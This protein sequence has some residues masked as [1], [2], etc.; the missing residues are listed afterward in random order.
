[1][2]KEI[3][4]LAIPNVISNITIPLL[5]MV[6]MA[7]MGRMESVHYI[8]A[9]GLGSMIF[10]FI[11]WG[12]GFLRMGTSGFTSQ[13]FGR[14]DRN[15]T[16]AGLFR[17]LVV[18]L[19]GAITVI[20]LQVPIAKLGFSL[21]KG[22]Q[23]VESLA[24]SYFYIRIWA[25]PATIAIY[26]FTGW[27]VG[28]QNAKI[29]MFVAIII[30]GLNIIFNVL[31]VFV[32]GMKSDGVALG[33]VLAQYSGLLFCVYFLI[34]KYHHYFQFVTKK[35][36]FQLSKFLEFFSVGKDIF[37]R[38][39]LLVLVIS[40]IQAESARIDSTILAVNNVLLQ[41]FTL[42]SYFADGFAHAAEAIGGKYF[43]AGNK[44]S[45][46]KTVKQT[47]KW[48]IF[49]SILFSLVYLI[50]NKPMIRIFTDIPEIINSATTYIVWII[51]VPVVSFAAFL[52]DGIYIGT[53]TSKGL[54]NT[55]IISAMSFFAM[56]YLI[57]GWD[58]NH[59]LWFCFVVFLFFRG[60]VQSLL[61]K[62]LILSKF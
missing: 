51:I 24:Q 2:N 62:R 1:M 12:F 30:N 25:A 41:F 60:L 26:A 48:G 28:M 54:R 45:F 14:N 49:V 55:M 34:R 22:E 59:I 10:N 39:F 21:I 40:F 35:L 9:I 43:G 42:F 52:W 18:A 15:E 6:D 13:A 33:T 57:N 20:A 11:Y 3:L 29:P 31:F 27:F 37:I 4:R 8:G 7:L 56:Y 16:I 23:E 47:F 44:T 53:T 5:G 50:L 19:I 32:F 38:T 46:S 61:Y 58:K 17:A 36:V